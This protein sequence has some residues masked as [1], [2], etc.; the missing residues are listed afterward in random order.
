MECIT[1][2]ICLSA[3]SLHLLAAG[4]S[5]SAIVYF[6]CNPISAL[7]KSDQVSE[8]CYDKYLHGAMETSFADCSVK[9]K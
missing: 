6:Y 4:H 9:K 8:S 5:L 2:L 1:K 7:K 3:Y